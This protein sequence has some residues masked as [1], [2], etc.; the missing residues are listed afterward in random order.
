M[1]GITISKKKT[2]AINLRISKLL[3]GVR[4]LYG[5]P[6]VPAEG[7]TAIGD[8]TSA[9]AESNSDA[10]LTGASSTRSDDRPY[11]ENLDEWKDRLPKRWRNKWQRL[12][13]KI[14]TF[15]HLLVMLRTDTDMPLTV[16][17]DRL[18][19]GR[20]FTPTE[21]AEIAENINR[22]RLEAFHR[23]RAKRG[24]KIIVN[25]LANL[26]FCNRHVS[27]KG[28][29][30]VTNL[31]KFD[32]VEHSPLIYR[33]HVDA[34]RLP[35]KV[36]I[37]DLYQDGVCTTLSASVEH[38]VRAK[39]EQIETYVTGLW[40]EIE[41]AATLG[42]PNLCK[43][44]DLLPLIPQSASPLA[45]IIGYGENKRPYVR[46]LEEMPHFLG[47]GQTSGGKSNFMHAML[48]AFIARNMPTD[49]RL[50][51][52]DMKFNGIELDRYKGLPHMVTDIEELPDGI[53]GTP[54]EAIKVLRWIVKEGNRRGRMFKA[55]GTQNL[56]A[57]NNKHRTRKMPRIVCMSDELALLRLDPVHGNEAYNLIREISSVARAAGI[58]L[59]TFTQSSNKRV[60][61]E[62]IKVNFPGRICFSVPD[63]SSSILFVGDGS[64]INLMPAGRARFK[65]GTDNFLAQTPLIQVS[66]ITEIVNNA[67]A[68]KTTAKLSKTIVTPEEVIEWSIDNNNSSL[69]VADV[70]NKFNTRLEKSGVER[71]LK[72][73]EGGTFGIGDRVYQVLPGA[74][75][76]P[77][78]VVKVE[79]NGV[80]PA[81]NMQETTQ[82]TTVTRDEAVTEAETI[83]E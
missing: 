53:A 76:R 75:K 14:K 46:S 73:M 1:A 82:D 81:V 2:T 18:R 68:G 25:S 51:M 10:L 29:A 33:Y 35:Y 60:I 80:S 52:I 48:C 12:W 34:R 49:L 17:V 77:R 20:D 36:S 57:W 66:E 47:G 31:I 22:K 32:R 39:I 41:I 40:Y 5:N 71:L 13:K 16:R 55:E 3:T 74:G 78:I 15:Y 6:D 30:K 50:L 7:E 23:E 19:M 63:A 26:G 11:V 83:G 59:V 38:P 64:A 21:R 65:H 42:I 58:H 69:A 79:G 45:F 4:A 62:M 54:E 70:Y 37:M 56:K 9:Q 61:D 28:H 72:E 67:K 8:I 43:F 27:E 44:S 24:E